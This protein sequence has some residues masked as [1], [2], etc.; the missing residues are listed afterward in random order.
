MFAEFYVDQG[1]VD[2]GELLDGHILHL[3]IGDRN[4]IAVKHT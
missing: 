4:S 1:V 2:L 3:L